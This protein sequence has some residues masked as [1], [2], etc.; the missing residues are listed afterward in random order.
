[1]EKLSPNIQFP[2]P[3]SWADFKQIDVENTFDLDS[4]YKI[5]QSIAN[6]HYE[7]FP[8]ASFFIPKHLRKHIYSIYAFARYA[9]DIADEKSNSDQATRVAILE[10]LEYLII[11]VD[12]ENTKHYPIILALNETI[13]QM[14]LPVDTI[15]RLLTAFKMDIYFSQPN[16]FDDLMNYCEYSAN[17]IGELILRLFNEYNEETAT[18]SNKI[19]SALQL[20]NF[21]QDI[22]IDLK[23]NR[24]YIPKSLMDQYLLQ[25]IPNFDNVHTNIENPTKIEEFGQFNALFEYLFSET[26]NLLNDGS[27]LINKLNNKKLQFEIK[28]IVN[29]GRRIL[30]KEKSRKYHLLFRRPKLNIIDYIRI[31]LKSILWKY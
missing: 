6:N 16:T 8:I 19:T 3:F 1:M 17:P 12:D 24:R 4:A 21:W 2:A 27:K 31:L 18:L 14:N 29:S 25:K 30:A 26:E 11:N 15:S 9:D 13:K 5:C 23:N 28:L 20:I 22:S 7:N 10:N